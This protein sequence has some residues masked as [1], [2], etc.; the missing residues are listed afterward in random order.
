MEH[1]DR[2][3]T[4]NIITFPGLGIRLNVD[5]TAFS[6]GGF[7]I[8]WYGIMIAIGLFL[9]MTYCFRRTKEFGIDG[10]KLTD[11]VFAGLVGAVIGARAY[12]VAFHAST[13]HDIMEVLAIRDGG[14][15]VYGGIIGAV[16]VGFVVAKIKKMRF[17]PTLDLA[18]MGFFI[19]QACGRWGN[20]FNQECFGT[21][22]SLPWG[23]SGGRVQDYLIYSQDS[24]AANG[25]T[26]DPYLPVHPCFLYESLWCAAGL[27]IMHLFHKK[28]KFD[29]ELICIYAAWYGIGRAVIEGLR[30][31]SLYAGS[32]RVSQVLA[33]ATAAIAIVIIVFMHIRTKKAGVHLYR[34]SKEAAAELAEAEKREQEENERKAN[35]KKKELSSDQKIIDDSEDNEP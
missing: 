11:V 9:A 18:S 23:M 28:R 24:F 31:D 33:A 15:A 14:L 3:G 8:K 27:L 19:G 17:L 13:Y 35:K 5:P 1:L 34:D 21:N 26:V 20:F 2:I 4:D 25:I 7:E 22:T 32:A 10:D 6:I 30:T 29:G 12:Y 16:L